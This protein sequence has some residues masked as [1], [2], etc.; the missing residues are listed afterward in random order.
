VTVTTWWALRYCSEIT[1]KTHS[2]SRS[3]VMVD[4]QVPLLWLFSLHLFLYMLQS[5][6]IDMLVPI[7]PVID[8]LDAQFLL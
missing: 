1:A 7:L 6:C 5:I 8:Q 2:M 3:I 4:L